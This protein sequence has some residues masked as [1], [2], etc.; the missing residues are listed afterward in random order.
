MGLFDTYAGVQLKIGDVC[1]R[2]FRVGHAVPI[3]DG[4][5]LAREGIVV[6]KEGKLLA[7]FEGD[8]I[9]FDKWGGKNRLGGAYQ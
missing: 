6:I 2:S 5:Y 8:D 1:L 9:I 3:P 4:I 7:S